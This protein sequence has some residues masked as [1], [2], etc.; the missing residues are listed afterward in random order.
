[1]KILTLILLLAVTLPVSSQAYLDKLDSIEQKLDDIEFDRNIERMRRQY[2][3]IDRDMER[4]RQQRLQRNE[5]PQPYVNTQTQ[6]QRIEQAKFWNLSISEYLKRDEIGSVRCTN[7]DFEISASSVSQFGDCWQSNMLNISIAELNIRRMKIH[8]NCNQS[9]QDPK[10]ME[11]AKR[12]L[13][14]AKEP[15][16][17]ININVNNGT[18]TLGQLLLIIL[19]LAVAWWIYHLTTEGE[20][21]VISQEDVKKIFPCPKCGQQCRVPAFKEIEVTCPSCKYIWK[22]KT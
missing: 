18:N 21:E 4:I 2:D 11:C 14:L 8:E 20:S 12:Y 19:G 15:N 9:F 6:E 22:L 7:N 10:F 1:M 3:Q 16:N 17:P 5:L 13:V